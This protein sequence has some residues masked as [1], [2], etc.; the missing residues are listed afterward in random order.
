MGTELIDMKSSLSQVVLLS[1]FALAATTAT[2]ATTAERVT[3]TW[4]GAVW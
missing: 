3:V 4:F 2:P 1:L